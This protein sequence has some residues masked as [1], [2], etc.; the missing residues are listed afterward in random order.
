M[1]RIGKDIIKSNK[2]EVDLFIN[3]LETSLK[4]QIDYIFVL[5]LHGKEMR[6]QK[7][8]PAIKFIDDYTILP[9]DASIDRYIIGIFYNDGTQINCVF[10]D[11][12]MAIDFLNRNAMTAK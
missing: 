9:K 12:Y 11:K 1:D 10:K 8:E 2:A 5:P 6:F 4:R 7:L 3:A